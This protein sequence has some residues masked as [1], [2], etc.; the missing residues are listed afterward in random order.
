MTI[1]RSLLAAAAAVAV[2]GA[3]VPAMA[4]SYKAEYSVSTVVPA[5]FPWGLTAERWATLVEERS[6]GRIQMR[7]HS[8]AELVQGQQTREFTAL[9]SGDI[10]MAVSSTINWSPQIVELNV[11][12]LPFLMP[13]Y[14]AIDA[15]TKGPVGERLFQLIEEKGV[16]PLAWAENGFREVTNSSRPI[17]TPADMQGLKM[18]VVAS[19]I[20]DDIF[21]ALGAE[22][23]EMSWAEAQAALGTGAVDG[24]ENPLTIYDVLDMHKFGQDNVTRWRY[25]ADPLILAVNRK[26]WD[27]FTPEDQE[28]VRR[29]AI[30]AGAYGVELARKGLTPGDQSLVEKIR[31]YGVDVIELSEE[32]SQVFVAATRS[33]YEAWRGRIGDD[34][35]KQ[36][37]ESV[38]KR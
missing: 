1:M 28:I 2:L 5:P 19:P 22:P 12:S 29:S 20:F 23:V 33:V 3:A 8:G 31:G 11:F 6:D 34:L 32:E 30:D 36:A 4:Q 18:R 7:I 15:L 16:V 35:V 25:V 9:S 26:V 27:S 38:A 21:A 13:D 10:D 37:E 14:A 17:R 24:Q